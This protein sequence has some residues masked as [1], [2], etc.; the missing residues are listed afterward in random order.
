MSDR[1]HRLYGQLYS[2]FLGQLRHGTAFPSKPAHETTSGDVAESDVKLSELSENE[3]FQLLYPFQHWWWPEPPEGYID[4]NAYLFLSRMPLSIDPANTVTIYE[5]SDKGLY[6]TYRNVLL[7][8]PK[9]EADTVDSSGSLADEPSEE[10]ITQYSQALSE[11]EM[12]SSPSEDKPGFMKMVTNAGTT[13]CENYVV[14]NGKDWISDLKRKAEKRH[15]NVIKTWEE[16]TLV[17]LSFDLSAALTS[18]STDSPKPDD[19]FFRVYSSGRKWENFDIALHDDNLSASIEVGAVRRV[20]VHPDPKWFDH[21]YL[22]TLAKRDSWNPPFTTTDIF[23]EKG[24]LSHKITKFL[25][26][27]HF[28]FKIT[29]SPDTFKKFEPHFKDAHGFCIGP[30]HFGAGANVESKVSTDW[31]HEANSET[32]TF[33]GESMVDYPTIIG[34]GVRR[35]L[36]DH[37]IK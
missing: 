5:P 20:G 27:H 14:A 4:Q 31:K 30:F 35:I 28:A 34:V 29:V 23:G 37:D 11:S 2:Q 16:D 13:A 21:R 15:S 25:A 36:H 3:D 22:H 1:D 32:S 7:S 12:P 24:L 6:S 19:A 26:A 9:V 10:W 17:N 18:T 8:C 33:E